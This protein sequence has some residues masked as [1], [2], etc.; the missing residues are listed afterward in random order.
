MLTRVMI[1]KN[2]ATIQTPDKR[3]KVVGLTDP[4]RTADLARPFVTEE[5]SR[6]LDAVTDAFGG[7]EAVTEYVGPDRSGREEVQ[8]VQED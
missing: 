2:G 6:I 4:R 8:Q 1:D 5:T 7:V 3:M